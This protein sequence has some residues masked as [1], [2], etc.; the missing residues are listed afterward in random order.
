MRVTLRLQ[1]STLT[2]AIKSETLRH[3]TFKT[4]LDRMSVAILTAIAVLAIQ[5]FV[6]FVRGF[7]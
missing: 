4:L 6:T 1:Y 5:L 3:S 2:D 7:L